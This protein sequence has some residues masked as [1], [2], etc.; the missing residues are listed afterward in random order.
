MY[1][2]DGFLR[3]ATM[4]QKLMG[5]IIALSFVSGCAWLHEPYPATTVEIIALAD[6][7]PNVL[8]AIA[9]DD[10]NQIISEVRVRQ[11][12]SHHAGFMHYYLMLDATPP[13]VVAYSKDGIKLTDTDST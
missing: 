4:R 9:D 12:H 10:S 3:G 2:S 8:S 5:I 1:D 11:F 13:R 6:L 7:P